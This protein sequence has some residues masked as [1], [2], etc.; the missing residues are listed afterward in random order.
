[1]S[2]TTSGETP[3][4]K[5]FGSSRGA[6]YGPIAKVFDD[7]W[8]AW[9]TTRFGPGA[10][11][12]RNMFVL[13][14]GDSLVA[15]HAVMMPDAQ[16]AE[17]EALGKV[18]HVV[19]LGDFHGMDD[20]LYKKRYGAKLWAPEGATPRDG[21]EP[22]HEM[23][24]GGET[25]F[26]GARLFRFDVAP[27][28]ETVIHL[29][30]HGGILLTCDS[31]QCWEPRPAGLSFLGSMMAGMMGFKGRACV[32]PFW[33]K[34]FEPKTGGGFEPK[35]RE[36]LDLEFRH[37]LSGHGPPMIDSAKDDLRATIDRLYPR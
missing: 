25:P 35:F 18:E 5:P 6:E 19:R 34:E 8:W 33:R 31:V 37:I 12:P 11:F 15:V 32:G 36:L 26:A 24:S 28:P 29:P 2:A 13:R 17:V 9:G 7:V 30:R 4:R 23:V 16:Q 22:D 10:T 14:E 1:M 3:K 21:A 20:A 27:F